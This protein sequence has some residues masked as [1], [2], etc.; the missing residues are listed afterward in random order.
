MRSLAIA[1]ALLLCADLGGV[2]FGS[3]ASPPPAASPA[4]TPVQE[5]TKITADAKAI[6]AE[7]VTGKVDRSH[8]S[9][10]LNK[11][12]SDLLAQTLSGQLS[13]LGAPNWIFNETRDTPEGPVQL[14]TLDYGNVKL[15]LS[16]GEKPDG[17]IWDL[18][19][20]Q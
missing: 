19:I 16:F 9:P 12:L 18:L 10:Q 8:L 17:T 14:Y 2:A 5:N 11:A 7:L 15:H 4:P 13:Q 20:S 3:T 6:Y 1:A